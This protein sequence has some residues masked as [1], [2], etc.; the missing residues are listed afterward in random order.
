MNKEN[1]KENILLHPWIVG[2][3][4]GLISSILF[5]GITA[6]VKKIDFIKAFLLIIK[7]I[8]SF[9]VLVLTFK[10]S[11]WIILLVIFFIFVL[12]FILSKFL[13]KQSNVN[14]FPDWYYNY[15]IDEFKGYLFKWNYYS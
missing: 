11:L 13:Q 3:G 4:T 2:S 1:K 14:K 7:N 12:L 6:L 5:V 8:Y 9:F 10:I 15:K